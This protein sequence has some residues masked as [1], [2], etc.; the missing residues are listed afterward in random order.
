[1]IVEKDK[2][3]E[4]DI[5]IDE[6]SNEVKKNYSNEIYEKV[7]ENIEKNESPIHL[8]YLKEG[9]FKNLKNFFVK[10]NLLLFSFIY[11]LYCLSGIG[12]NHIFKSKLEENNNFDKLYD[13]Y[14]TYL[15]TFIYVMLFYYFFATL[16]YF[17]ANEFS[18]K[19]FFEFYNFLLLTTIILNIF[20]YSIIYITKNKNNYKE[21]NNI[22]IY[23]QVYCDIF[24]FIFQN[25]NTKE[26]GNNFLKFSSFISIIDFL[27]YLIDFLLVDI[28]ECSIKFLFYFGFVFSIIGSIILLKYY[29]QKYICNRT[30]K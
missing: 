3:K 28:F 24:G 7:I 20:I 14:I 30:N 19:Q 22:P 12:F 8:T 6:I 9:I 5:E 17:R 29:I 18:G 11:I 10:N 21:Y 16:I 4:N 25:L 27:L 1:M 26:E 13:I 2:K 23:S 15:S